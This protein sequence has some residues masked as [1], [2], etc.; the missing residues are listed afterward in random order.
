[1]LIY[2]EIDLMVY[3]YSIEFWL[4]RYLISAPDV[5]SAI[6]KWAAYSCLSRLSVYLSYFAILY[7]SSNSD[8]SAKL[9]W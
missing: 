6:S 2:D 7:L 9:A 1:M 3:S 8:F 5:Y 4:I